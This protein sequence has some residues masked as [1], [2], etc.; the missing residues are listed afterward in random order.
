MLRILHTSDWHLG[1]TLR[2]LDRTEEHRIFLQWL[3]DLLEERHEKGVPFH[4]TLVS[5]D[6]FDGPNPSARAQTLFYDFVERVRHFTRL[7]VTAGNH[8]SAERL[9]APSPLLSRLQVQVVGAWPGD[10]ARELEQMVVPIEGDGERALVL[11]MPFLRLGD[12][13]AFAGEDASTHFVTAHRKRYQQLFA[14]A[15]KHPW[16]N[17]QVALVGMGHCYAAGASINEETERRVGAQDE[18]PIDIFP[19]Q[20]IYVALGHLHKAQ[21]VGGSERVRYSG[22][23]LPLGFSEIA[24]HHQV[25]AVTIANG[26]LSSVQSIAVPRPRDFLQVPPK[27]LPWSEVET[28]LSMLERLDNRT[29]NDPLRPLLE[30]RVQPGLDRPVDLRERV[31][32]VLADKWPLLFR[33]DVF[34]ETS[35][36][37]SANYS[38]NVRSLEDLTPEDVF[39]A[40]CR[41]RGV[42]EDDLLTLQNDFQ[43]L[44]TQFREQGGTV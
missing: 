32:A 44:L 5:G 43:S 13:G 35:G 33:I 19:P 26:N 24:Y 14:I 3:G 9:Q 1:Q 16:Y 11:A 18:L 21:R 42:K 23:P 6:L 10:D 31:Q 8:D 40:L 28:A 22:S 15:Q 2:D 34:T 30:V 36:E 38:D 7:I 37:G 41:E 17:P 12:L 4:A 27:H 25:L 29:G 39:Q 20:L